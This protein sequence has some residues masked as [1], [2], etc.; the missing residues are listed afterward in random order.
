[1][2]IP[3]A[4]NR[5]SHRRAR[6]GL[7][8]QLGRLEE[9]RH[10][11]ARPDLV[12][13][14]LC[15]GQQGV[16]HFLSPCIPSLP[17]TGIVELS[18]YIHHPI[19]LFSITT[20]TRNIELKHTSVDSLS[21]GFCSL[22]RQLHAHRCRLCEPREAAYGQL[23]GSE[24]PQGR[25]SAIASVSSVCRFSL[26]FYR[27]PVYPPCLFLSCGMHVEDRVQIGIDVAERRDNKQAGGRD[28]RNR[29]ES[30]RGG[31]EIDQGHE[32]TR[33]SL[34]PRDRD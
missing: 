11:Q 30:Y 31:T 9:Q 1:V 26:S 21:R 17:A 19:V 27:N 8:R 12:Q 2:L 23:A 13:G 22:G 6:R 14:V 18:P 34:M 25:G 29:Q 32:I 15:L 10:H 3:I 28:Q 5:D 16:G 20:T 24:T 7:P 33:S 4:S